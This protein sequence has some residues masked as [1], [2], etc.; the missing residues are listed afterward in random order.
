MVFTGQKNRDVYLVETH[1]TYPAPYYQTAVYVNNL[2]INSKIL[3]VGD[4]R[5]LYYKRDYNASSVFDKQHFLKLLEKAKG[6]ESFYNNLKKERFTHI[7]FNIM[8]IYRLIRNCDQVKILYEN[9]D[10]TEISILKE[11]WNKYLEEVNVEYINL[12]PKNRRFVIL[13]K[14]LSLEEANQPHEIPQNYFLP[15]F[16]KLKV[17]AVN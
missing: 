13:Y 14:L 5:G 8:E 10:D 7:L 9:V 17:K 2:P 4:A 6:S 15:V 16:D 3:I 1:K 12:P 11:F